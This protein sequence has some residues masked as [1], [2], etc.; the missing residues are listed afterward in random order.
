MY[1]AVSREVTVKYETIILEKKDNIATLTL[2]RPHK[3]NA[4]NATFFEELG[5]ALHRVEQDEEVRVLIITGAGRAFSTGGDIGMLR[6]MFV[7]PPEKQGRRVLALE[8]FRRKS[9]A[10]L[11]IQKLPKPV[12]A[13]VNGVAAGGGL[14]LALVTDIRIA[15]E[16]ATF[17]H[18]FA[19]RGLPDGASTYLLPKLVGVSKA[20]EL[21]Y[22]GDFIDAREAERIGLVNKVVPHDRLMQSAIELAAKIAKGPPITYALTK[23]AM[24]R[25]L[26]ATD[27]DLHLDYEI[28]VVALTMDTQDFEE[29]MT[30]FLEKREPLFRGR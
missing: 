16:K 30:A 24:Y 18:V 1:G 13:A 4:M 17:S 10:M 2:N 21:A 28:K 5:D 12:I 23:D 8:E 27:L 15:S 29:G 14:M 20:L 25:G 9:G 19:R 7:I 22:T 26:N 3:M 11:E 6:D